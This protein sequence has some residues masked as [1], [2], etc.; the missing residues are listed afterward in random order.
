MFFCVSGASGEMVVVKDG[1]GRGSSIGG[2]VSNNAVT[3]AEPEG[4]MYYSQFLQA[5]EGPV[6]GGK[7]MGVDNGCGFSGRK[8]VSSFS[9]ESGDSLRNILSDPIT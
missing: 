5:S 3:I 8:E 2:Q 7:D 9:N 6:S 4:D 1:G